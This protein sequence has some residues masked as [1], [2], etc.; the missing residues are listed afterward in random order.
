MYALAAVGTTIVQPAVAEVV[1]TPV[2]ERL[3]INQN[4]QID[5]NHDGMADFTFRYW[6]AT[7]GIALWVQGAAQ[8][9]LVL[10][11][12]QASILDSHAVIGIHR[13]FSRFAYPMLGCGL[14]FTS[15][16]VGFECQLP[17]Y[18]VQ[19]KYVG[20]EFQI[21]GKTHYGWARLNV[22]VEHPPGPL[23]I[24]ATLTGYAYETI[25]YKRIIAGETSGPD[26]VTVQTGS[27]GD[28]AAGAARDTEATGVQ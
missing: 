9:N 12:R 24:E 4:V 6:S 5:L 13:H 19:H 21:D 10:G 2:K 11:G 15:N 26:V 3:P 14:S 17:W 25:P 28:L 1:Y 27:L 8:S 22:I 18:N 23:E 20:L 16:G 7:G